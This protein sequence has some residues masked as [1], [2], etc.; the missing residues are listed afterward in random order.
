MAKEVEIQD[1]LKILSRKVIRSFN[2][3]YQYFRF[4]GTVTEVVARTDDDKQY[5]DEKDKI[6]EA[7][8]SYILNTYIYD[9]DTD[10]Y[11]GTY[12]RDSDTTTL[13]I[14]LNTYISKVEDINNEFNKLLTKLQL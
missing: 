12:Y 13:S 11:I 8:Y 9:Q 10:I 1:K 2:Y 3:T 4:E 6:E 5:D 14:D 7:E